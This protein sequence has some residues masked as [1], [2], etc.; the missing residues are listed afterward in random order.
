MNTVRVHSFHRTYTGM[1]QRNYYNNIS[2]EYSKTDSDADLKF[3]FERNR[4]YVNPNSK[5]LSH[6]KTV[7]KVR[8]SI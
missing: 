8:L 2:I 6:K 7:K 3:L 1:Y 5:L 4:E